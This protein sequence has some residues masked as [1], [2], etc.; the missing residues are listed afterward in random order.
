M[1]G[2]PGS[3]VLVSPK[4]PSTLSCRTLFSGVQ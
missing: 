1:T 4:G 2:L 3:V